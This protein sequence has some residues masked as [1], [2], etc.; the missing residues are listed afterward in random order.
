M[1]AIELWCY[2]FPRLYPHPLHLVSY[3]CTTTMALS[4][5]SKM[6][7]S[8]NKISVFVGHAE[9]TLIPVQLEQT[10]AITNSFLS[11]C[12]YSNSEIIL[13]Y[14]TG[15]CHLARLNAI[16]KGR[17]TQRKVQGKESESAGQPLSFFLVGKCHYQREDSL[18]W[19]GQA[20]GHSWIPAAE[21]IRV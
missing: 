17:N 3:E 20:G 6:P 4:N 2:A 21:W 16:Y 11:L 1:F 15:P 12:V 5:G 14:L 7:F 10:T 9:V 18:R 8:R 19:W 13:Q